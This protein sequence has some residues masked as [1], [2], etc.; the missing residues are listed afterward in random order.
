MVST[1]THEQFYLEVLKSTLLNEIPIY[2]TNPKNIY[3]IYRISHFETSLGSKFTEILIILSD[4]WPQ[5]SRALLSKNN[6]CKTVSL[7]VGSPTE[8]AHSYKLHLALNRL[9][10]SQKLIST[11]RKKIMF[12]VKKSV[13]IK[14]MITMFLS[15]KW[16]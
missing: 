15:H 10:F 6:K 3:R 8:I 11:V 12:L 13:I 5:V 2:K 9:F 14:K 1:W 16:C 4:P 7:R